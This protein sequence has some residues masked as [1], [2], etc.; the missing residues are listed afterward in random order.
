MQNKWHYLNLAICKIVL[1]LV[2]MS[3]LLKASKLL[4]I[5]S[6]VNVILKPDYNTIIYVIIYDNKL[7]TFKQWVL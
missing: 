3:E 1:P 5:F 6:K 7:I 2:S 4:I